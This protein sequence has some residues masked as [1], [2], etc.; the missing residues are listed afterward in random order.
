[1]KLK[2]PFK[3]KIAF[4]GTFPRAIKKPPRF[5]FGTHL[6]NDAKAEIYPEVLSCTNGE[7]VIE[8]RRHGDERVYDL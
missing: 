6:S 7:W 4:G 8:T 2:S 3:D 5:Q 1:M